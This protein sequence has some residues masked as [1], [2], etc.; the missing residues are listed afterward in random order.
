MEIRRQIAH[1]TNAVT[2][3]DEQVVVLA[4]KLAERPNYVAD[5]GAN[6]EVADGPNVDADAHG[7]S[8]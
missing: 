6:A 2:F 8:V 4:V 3:A 5:V 1:L 7:N